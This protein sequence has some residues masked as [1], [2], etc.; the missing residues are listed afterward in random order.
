MPMTRYRDYTEWD[1]TREHRE[2]D[3]ATNEATNPFD[4]PDVQW[5]MAELI[6]RAA[7]SSSF[8]CA[9]KDTAN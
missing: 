3:P 1:S 8:E 2:D 5:R 9:R 7:T 4:D 6:S